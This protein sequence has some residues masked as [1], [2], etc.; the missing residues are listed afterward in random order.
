M[1]NLIMLAALS[2]FTWYV[3]PLAF[4]ISLVYSTSRY[5]LPKRIVRRTVRLFT[6]IIGFMAIVFGGLILLSLNL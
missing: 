4:V 5:E 1:Q 2:N 6:T 3:F